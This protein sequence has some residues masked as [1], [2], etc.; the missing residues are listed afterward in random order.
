MQC[1]GSCRENISDKNSCHSQPPP[2]QT[3]RPA[4][5]SAGGK[6]EIIGQTQLKIVRAKL[7]RQGVE[8]GPELQCKTKFKTILD[9]I[10]PQ[11]SY[12]F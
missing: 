10:A 9:T 1:N 8:P 2:D 3:R 4:L 7:G 6:Q 12:L 5:K 11:V